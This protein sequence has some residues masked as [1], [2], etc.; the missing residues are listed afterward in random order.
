MVFEVVSEPSDDGSCH[1][2]MQTWI[3]Q[4]SFIHTCTRTRVWVSCTSSTD[5]LDSACSPKRNCVLVADADAQCETIGLA[6]ADF[7]QVAYHWDKA[8]VCRW[9]KFKLIRIMLLRFSWIFS[10]RLRSFAWVNGSNQPALFQSLDTGINHSSIALF[11]WESAYDDHNLF[12]VTLIFFWRLPD[13]EESVV[14]LQLMMRSD[15]VTE[16]MLPL[17][18]PQQVQNYIAPS[19]IFRFIALDFLESS[20]NND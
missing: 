19:L 5:F 11:L 2:K 7:A 10:K 18:H 4:H 20:Q 16:L 8:W 17:H 15:D 9:Y 13:C 12:L 3:I 6:V 14:Y 1:L